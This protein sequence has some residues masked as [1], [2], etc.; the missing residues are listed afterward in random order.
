V[1]RSPITRIGRSTS[2]ASDTLSSDASQVADCPI[3]SGGEGPGIGENYHHAVD[4]ANMFVAVF[5]R[6]VKT[7]NLEIR[8]SNI[9][10]DISGYRKTGTAV[11]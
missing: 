7:C 3:S 8:K 1:P 11:A 5:T 9:N 4:F 6:L 2:A 10:R